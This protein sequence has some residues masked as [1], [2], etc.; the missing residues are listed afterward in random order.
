MVASGL[1]IGL[2]YGWADGRPF[3]R[4]RQLSD[5][6]VHTVPMRG[7]L[8][9]AVQGDR[10]CTG[11]FDGTVS[12][13]CPQGLSLRS[14]VACERCQQRDAFRPCMR[15]DGTRC[16]PLAPAMR[17][18]CRQDHHLYLACFGD[19]TIKVGTASHPRR[20][21][22]IVEQGP[23]AAARV[24]RGEGPRIKQLE[25]WL[26][27]GAFTETMRRA[28]KTALLSGSMS[29]EEAEQR[30][31][32]AAERLRDE[33]PERFV[34]LLHTPELVQAPP[35]AVDSR[36][37]SVQP[38]QLEPGV[39]LAGEVVGAVGHVV[40]LRDDDGVFAFDLGE[41]KGRVVDL[42]PDD[43]GRKPVVQ[44]GLF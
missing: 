44:L 29:V 33:L 39:V 43:G 4:V 32:D 8:R 20:R 21:Q 35:L 15:C 7:E 16:P 12:H 2:G 31:L 17:R 37:L 5:Q 3:L 18:Y 13:P 40:F 41:L 6:A 34:G 19:D 26:S 1:S 30:V 38:V 9:F 42:S 27:Q 10:R 25:R 36:S 11:Y 14:G 23:L 24:A 28:R 22:R